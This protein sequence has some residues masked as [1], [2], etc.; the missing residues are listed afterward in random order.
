VE[1][2]ALVAVLFI[3]MYLGVVQGALDGGRLLLAFGLALDVCSRAL[4]TIAAN[5]AGSDDWA[6]LCAL[7]GSPFVASFALFGRGGAVKVE[8]APLAGLMGLVAL[9]ALA[10]ALVSGA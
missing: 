2:V 3:E 7:G 1:G 5:R 6:W 4:G 9:G 8:P 10:I